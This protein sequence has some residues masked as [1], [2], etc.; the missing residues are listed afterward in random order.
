L[1]LVESALAVHVAELGRDHEETAR[2]HDLRA[3]L[4]FFVGDLDGAL[5]DYEHARRVFERRFEPGHE[6]LVVLWANLGDTLL[7]LGRRPEAK[8]AFDESLAQ[9]DMQLGRSHPLAAVALA[10]RGEIELAEGHPDAAIGDLEAALSLLD[11]HD[12]DAAER[13]ATQLSL[14]RALTAVGRE[15]ERARELRASAK[16][17]F[18]ALGLPE[19]SSESR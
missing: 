13:A 5:A 9:L 2:L 15:G 19:P 1:A 12:G 3:T 7:A 6:A 11:G 8:Q 10:G 18:V 16:A 14:A 17:T 4:R